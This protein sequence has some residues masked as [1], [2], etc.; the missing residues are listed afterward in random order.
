MKRWLL[1]TNDVLE[2]VKLE[3]EGELV[4]KVDQ[5]IQ[6]GDKV[7]VYK[8]HPHTHI[9]HI[10]EVKETSSKVKNS[11][12]LTI[13]NKIT[14]SEP[15]TLA[16]IKKRN[17]LSTWKKKFVKRFHHV[18]LR[19][20]SQIIGVI[21]E[22]NPQLLEKFKPELC[23]GPDPNGY[24][25]KLK[26]ELKQ[27]QKDIKSY[28]ISFFNEEATKYLMVLPVLE[29]LGWNIRNP[30]QVYPEYRVSDKKVDYVLV[31]HKSSKIFVEAKKAGENDLDNHEEQILNYCASKNVDMG[32]LTNGII[33]RF[34]T[35]CYHDNR[36]GAIKELHKDEINLIKDKYSEIS[37]KFL[38][39]FWKGKTCRMDPPKNIESP[40]SILKK[41]KKIKKTDLKCYNES[42]TK[43]VII[44]PLIRSFGWN[45]RDTSHFIYDQKIRDKKVDYVL[46]SNGHRFFIEAKGL[47]EDLEKYDVLIRE[48]QHI[49]DFGDAGDFDYGVLT[50]GDIWRFYMIKTRDCYEI[51]VRPN[52]PESVVKELNKLLSSKEVSS[53]G[54][55]KYLKKK[56]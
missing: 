32:I 2:W 4:F 50:N 13:N 16:E 40:E 44:L 38:D 26:T 35:I 52:R 8:S 29:K 54:H 41:V 15:V 23:E 1:V 42:A 39:Y 6:K 56:V 3:E 11:Y 14:I 28:D 53:G 46:G 24:P 5:R 27:V 12:N 25:V 19:D 10:F 17:K 45:I 20:W 36:L 33:W 21:M 30:R 43:Q 31:D 37:S 48:E 51:R 18:P 22:K 34:Y 7:L 55:L 9:S 49:L 47:V